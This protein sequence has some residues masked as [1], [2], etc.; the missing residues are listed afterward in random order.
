[1]LAGP[2]H[3]EMRPAGI[4]VL[5]SEVSDYCCCVSSLRLPTELSGGK[6]LYEHAGFLERLQTTDN[7]TCYLDDRHPINPC[8]SFLFP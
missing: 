2:L 8:Q 7:P 6:A 5:D 4:R 1:M 3:G